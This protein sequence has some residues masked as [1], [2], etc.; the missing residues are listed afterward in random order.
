MSSVNGLKSVYLLSHLNEYIHLCNL[1]CT[2]YFERIPRQSHH[3][4]SAR[5]VPLAQSSSSRYRKKQEVK[6]V[7]LSFDVVE[8]LLANITVPEMS[9]G[10][11]RFY[12]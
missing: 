9:P 1:I 2:F 10:K 6:R 12:F 7:F 8:E 11:S 3:V 5:S 4:L